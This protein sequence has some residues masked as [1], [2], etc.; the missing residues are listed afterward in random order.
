MSVAGYYEHDCGPAVLEDGLRAY[1]RTHYNPHGLRPFDS[2]VFVTLNGARVLG[3]WT[4]FHP[5]E[6]GAGYPPLTDFRR[7]TTVYTKARGTHEVVYGET[8]DEA[9]V[10][11]AVYHGLT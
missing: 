1:A 8:A 3:E 5:G 10:R 9:R 4:C 7:I 6:V 2:V 11:V